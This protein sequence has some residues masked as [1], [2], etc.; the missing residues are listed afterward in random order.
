M[1]AKFVKYK[2]GAMSD[3]D[4]ADSKDLVVGQ[5]YEVTCSNVSTGHTD[6]N[7]RGV[8]GQFNSVWFDEVPIHKAF[9]TAKPVVGYPMTCTKL[10]RKNEDSIVM[11]SWN[12]TKVEKI[13]NIESGTFRVITNNSVYDVMVP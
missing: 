4:C 1:S 3:Y 10:E 5:I 8:I 6:Y 9:A 11:T 2:G 13:D 12:T 7:L